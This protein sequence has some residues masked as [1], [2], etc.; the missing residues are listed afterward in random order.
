[1]KSD[2]IHLTREACA[3][4]DLIGMT[5]DHER[6]RE[7]VQSYGTTISNVQSYETHTRLVKAMTSDHDRRS[8]EF[9][10]NVRR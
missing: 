10:G 9:D 4:T 5:A 3:S 1:M 7:C 8:K 2:N 6:K